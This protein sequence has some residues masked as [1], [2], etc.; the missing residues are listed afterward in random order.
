MKKISSILILTFLA[1]GI[2]SKAS[3]LVSNSSSHYSNQQIEISNFSGIEIGGAINA[4]VKLGNTESLK[5]EGDKE[6]I[7]NIIAEV[8]NGVLTIKPK[9]QSNDW[10]KTFRGS[11]ITAYI[12]AKKITSLGLSG[13][14]S[15][16]VEGTIN[17]S[18]LSIVLSG[19]GKIKTSTN[20]TNF[21]GAI[22]GS[23]GMT[24][25]GKAKESAIKVSGSGAF[26]GKNF[27]VET[28][29]ARVSGSGNVHIDVQKTIN[30][31]ISGS[32]NISYSG[33][34][35]IQKSVS[36]SGSVRKI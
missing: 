18:S 12:T 16:D 31:S 32:G 6:A 3:N 8:K 36:G 24:I 29:S 23:G 35:I 10:F 15:I 4:V 11:K 14:G 30:A 25:N 20:V 26:S 5:L 34:P 28:L 9:K 19:S 21:E 2:V 33:D 27:S 17:S 1:F 22:S 7:N 13:S